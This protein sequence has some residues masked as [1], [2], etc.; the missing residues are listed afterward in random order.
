MKVIGFSN[1]RKQF[2]ILARLSCIFSL[3]HSLWSLYFGV[4]L[5]NYYAEWPQQQQP[6]VASC[7]GRKLTFSAETKTALFNQLFTSLGVFLLMFTQSKL[8]KSAT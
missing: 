4:P 6:T 2:V 7:Q 3:S 1:N 5:S 8:G